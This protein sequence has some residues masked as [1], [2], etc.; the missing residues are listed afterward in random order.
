MATP[1]G[2]A[3]DSN[4][5]KFVATFNEV[6]GFHDALVERV[7]LDPSGR[8]LRLEVDYIAKW[9]LGP[10]RRRWGPRQLTLTRRDLEIVFLNVRW[11]AVDLDGTGTGPYRLYCMP[12]ERR[13][14]RADHPTPPGAADI[15][16]V[17][18]ELSDIHCTPA[19][20]GWGG[21]Y[22][23]E[24]EYMMGDDVPG[25]ICLACQSCL[26]QFKSPARRVQPGEARIRTVAKT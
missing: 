1:V 18:F 8:S 23:F 4:T 5:P 2:L 25:I 9:E 17:G 20:A 7:E 14:P 19:K 16:T 12:F 15:G 6:F 26:L 22:H 13:H 3:L 11:L 24:F 10:R 21:G